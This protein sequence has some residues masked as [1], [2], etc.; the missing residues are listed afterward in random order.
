M[1]V[2]RTTGSRFTVISPTKLRVL[3]L[4]WKRFDMIK[5]YLLLTQQNNKCSPPY[6]VKPGILLHR[7]SLSFI[8]PETKWALLSSMKFSRFRAGTSHVDGFCRNPLPIF[9]VVL[10]ELTVACLTCSL[11]RIH[12]RRTWIPGW[13]SPGL[14][15]IWTMTTRFVMLL[16]NAEN[17]TAS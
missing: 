8:R 17:E 2:P 9:K 15:R 14:L 13:R 10:R 6:V 1:A 5:I 4:K 12:G 3:D 16:F 7:L 11:T